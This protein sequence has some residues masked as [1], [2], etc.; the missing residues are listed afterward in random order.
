MVTFTLALCKVRGM[1][2]HEHSFNFKSNNTSPPIDN[3]KP[4]KSYID[5]DPLRVATPSWPTRFTYGIASEEVKFIPLG[6]VWYSSPEVKQATWDS[7][8]W[9]E[10]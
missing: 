7:R 3:S 9:Q 2:Y 5:H 6:L 8:P 10:T 1:E 4:M